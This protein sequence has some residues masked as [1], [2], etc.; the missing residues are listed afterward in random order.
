MPTYDYQCRTCGHRFEYFQSISADAL[1]HCPKELCIQQEEEK[2]KKEKNGKKEGGIPLSWII[3]VALG[4]LAMIIIIAVIR[5]ANRK[6]DTTDVLVA[7]LGETGMPSDFDP[8]ALG[9]GYPG[10]EMHGSVPMAG[11]DGPFA[12]LQQMDPEMVADLLAQERSGTAAGVLG[13]MD[14]GYAD[15]VLQVMPP[16]MQ[17]DLIQRLQTQA[18]LPAFQQKTVAQQLKRRLGVPT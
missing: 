7:S 11:E 4:I 17:E 18:P 16:E 15:L 6:E 9:G 2:K 5:L 3:G 14:P 12:F 13:L 10:M 1:T 8:N